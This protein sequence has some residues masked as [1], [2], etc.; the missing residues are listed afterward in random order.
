[1]PYICSLEQHNK[2]CN[3]ILVL[4]LV[5]VEMLT[6]SRGGGFHVKADGELKEVAESEC[7]NFWSCMQTLLLSTLRYHALHY[8]SAL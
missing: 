8:I 4:L 1:M 3:I 7:A 2:T 5:N 6:F